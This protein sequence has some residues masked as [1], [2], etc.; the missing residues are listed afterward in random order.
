MELYLLLPLTPLTTHATISPED[1][2]RH[3]K[4][5]N[6]EDIGQDVD[7]RAPH[8]CLLRSGANHRRVETG[9]NKVRVPTNEDRIDDLLPRH[10]EHSNIT[11]AQRNKAQL[12][13]A[14]DRHRLRCNAE[15]ISMIRL[16]WHRIAARTKGSQ[17]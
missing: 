7:D 12:P 13:V 1:Q 5:R 14:G 3:D 10:I 15:I 16:R 2:E 11:P 4:K 9:N 6:H 8:R 17:Y